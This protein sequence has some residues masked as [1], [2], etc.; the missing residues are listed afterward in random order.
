[1][2]AS[3]HNLIDFLFSPEFIVTSILVWF[4]IIFVFITISIT[5]HLIILRIF[6][7]IPWIRALIRS[8]VKRATYIEPYE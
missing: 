3:I 4:A 8:I 7:F 5:F 2:Q 1:M 6:M